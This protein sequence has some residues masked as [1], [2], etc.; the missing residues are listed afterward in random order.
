VGNVVTKYS[1][2]V[3]NWNLEREVGI[4]SKKEVKKGYVCKCNVWER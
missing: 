4:D 2:K 1:G 3:Y